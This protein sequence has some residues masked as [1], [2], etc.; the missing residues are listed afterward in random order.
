MGKNGPAPV[1][2]RGARDAFTGPTWRVSR[3]NTNSEI[4]LSRLKDTA[5]NNVVVSES[6]V[7]CGPRIKI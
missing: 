1:T 6:K 4:A 3:T 5:F 2:G 7:R